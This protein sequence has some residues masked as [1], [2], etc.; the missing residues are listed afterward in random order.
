M[1]N[2]VEKNKKKLSK[3]TFLFLKIFQNGILQIE[4]K[5]TLG[6]FFLKKIR[7][8][9]AKSSDLF[10]PFSKIFCETPLFVVGRQ[11]AQV[12]LDPRF[13]GFLTLQNKFGTF[14]EFIM[15]KGAFFQLS[16]IEE[17][18]TMS[19][20]YGARG[21]IKFL[22]YDITFKIEKIDAKTNSHAIVGAQKKLFQLPEFD[23]PI[24]RKVIP[25]SMLATALT[26]IPLLLWLVKS[27]QKL[28]SGIINL[29]T[30]ILNEF[31]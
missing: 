22:G 27:P 28:Q 17:P 2:D 9:N 16:S 24:E 13:E 30:N 10:I 5:V 8:G 19:L 23:D 4:K 15:P 3:N 12:I 25:I 6:S 20:E 31:I 18:M 7:I 11:S 21:K 29:S 1:K 14:S 26:F